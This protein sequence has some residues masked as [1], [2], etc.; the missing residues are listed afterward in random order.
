MLFSVSINVVCTI[1][2]P[3]AA[4]L[5]YLAMIA[6]RIGEGIGGGVTFPGI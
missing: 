3:L 1:L 2:T 6:M 4:K 5:H